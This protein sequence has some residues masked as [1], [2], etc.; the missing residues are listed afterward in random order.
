M[1]IK[2]AIEV[3]QTELKKDEGYRISWQANIAMAFKDEMEIKGV[4]SPNPENNS[5]LVTREMLHTIAND[6]SDNFLNILM[7]Q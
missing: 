7:S 5:I 1:E 2:E 6:A 4:H 3:L